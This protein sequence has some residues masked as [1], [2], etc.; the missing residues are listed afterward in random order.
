MNKK[1]NAVI[2][3]EHM[4]LN[5][6]FEL[7]KQYFSKA[8]LI[9]RGFEFSDSFVKRLG[10][11]PYGKKVISNL[12]PKD[13]PPKVFYDNKGTIAVT[14]L[15]WGG[16]CVA[17]V[18]EELACL[19]VKNVIGLGA[20][21]SLKK[22]IRPGDIFIALS[23]VLSDG[24]SKEYIGNETGEVLAN[25]RLITLIKDVKVKSRIHRG[26]VWTTD[27]LYKETPSKIK[28]WRK[29]GA[30]AVNLEASTFYAVSEVLGIEA[31]YLAT[32][33]DYIGGAEWDSWHRD[34]SEADEELQKICEELLIRSN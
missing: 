14:H 7:G 34:L 5:R 8:V 32:V 12:N 16:P 10:F 9:F 19:G 28:E 15:L 4:F 30:L 24:T 23:G 26:K 33:S 18:L 11:E 21:G 29:R 2:R 31:I 27:A 3:A 20:V 17:I 6:D 1:D 25:Q 22:T 13:N